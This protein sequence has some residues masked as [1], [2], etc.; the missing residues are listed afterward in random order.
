MATTN[1][2]AAPSIIGT[3]VYSPFLK[4]ETYINSQNI[5][6]VSQWNQICQAWVQT[7]MSVADK[8][9]VQ[10]A[11]GYGDSANNATLL[12]MFDHHLCT[13]DA[14]N[15]DATD[16]TDSTKADT[17]VLNNRYFV[18]APLI[19][20]ILSGCEKL[21]PSLLMPQIRQVLTVDALTNFVDVVGSFKRFYIYNI[22]LTYQLIDFG[23]EVQHMV[24]TMPK[25]L[26]KS[27]GWANSATTLA[28]NIVGT[29]SVIFN[30]R[31]ASI[32]Y[33]LILANNGTNATNKSFDFMDITNSGT[34][35]VQIGSS[36]YPQLQLNSGTNKCAFI[37]EL[38]KAMDNLYDMCNS[39][40]INKIE[41]SQTDTSI[42]AAATVVSQPEKFIVGIDTTILGCG[43]S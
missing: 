12:S 32:K 36:A 3:P 27:N 42:T 7:N 29:T 4:L 19:C 24:E 16:G 15:D 17:V 30:Q 40:S 1:A 26:I 43:S 8:A 20:N 14:A 37:Q 5:E 23:A 21:L 22:Q 33:V 9:G 28:A 39:M 31:F 11:Y 38:R 41:F 6:S 2:A 10:Y 25:F 18:S 34:Y 13:R 35:Q